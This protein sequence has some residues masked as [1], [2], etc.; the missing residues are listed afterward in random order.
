MTQICRL[1]V[2]IGSVRKDRVGPIVARWLLGQI[3][4]HIGIQLD[5]VDLVDLELPDDLDNGGDAMMFRKRIDSADGFIVVTPEYNRG[6]PGALKTAI[7]T[8]FTEW[9]AKPV[10]FVSYGGISGGLRAVEQLRPVFAELHAVTMQAVVSVPFVWERMDEHGD[11]Y[12]PDRTASAAATLLRQL[13]WWAQTLRQ[14]K[15]HQTYQP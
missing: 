14:A 10:G 11:L 6:Y 2:I 1:A 5:V 12:P 7:D 9:H 8:A 15:A 3:R 4:P 13:T